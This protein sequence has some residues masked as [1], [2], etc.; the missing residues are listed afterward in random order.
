MADAIINLVDSDDDSDFEI[1]DLKSSAERVPPPAAAAAAPIIDVDKEY[2][3]AAVARNAI[4]VAAAP[5]VSLDIDDDDDGHNHDHKVGRKRKRPSFQGDE[6]LNIKP[7]A[8]P[9]NTVTINQ[10]Q[11]NSIPD[12][13]VC[14]T[15]LDEVYEVFPDVDRVYAQKLLFEQHNKANVVVAMLA[16]KTSY[17]KQKVPLAI[18]AAAA[19]PSITVKLLNNNAPKFDYFSPSS[20]E[21]SPVYCQQATQQLCF[22]FPYLNAKAV[23]GLMSKNQNHYS[24]VQRSILNALKGKEDNS[25]KPSEEEEEQHF[26]VLRN[27]LMT[28]AL[29]PKQIGRLG[30]NNIL[31]RNR[32]VKLPLITDKILKDE[33]AYAKNQLQEWMK[34]IEQRLQRVQARKV[35]QETGSAMECSCCFDQVAM[36]EMVACRDEGHLFCVDCIRSYAE[37]Q[38]FSCGNLGI[39]KNTKKPALHLLCCHSSGCQSPFQD[40]HLSKALPDK[41][42]QK[43]NELQFTAQVEQAGLGQDLCTCPKC[44]FQV[45]LPKTQMILQCPVEDCQFESCR[46]CGKESHIPYKCD[47]VVKLKQQDAGRLK[48]EEAISRAKIRT[49]PKCK[50]SF[51]KSDG[52]NKMACPCGLKLCYICRQPLPKHNPYSHFC[53]LPHCKHK[54]CGKCTLYSNNEE[55]DARAMREAGIGAAEEYRSELL[56]REEAADDVQINVDQ[57]LGGSSKT[58]P[59]VRQRQGPGRR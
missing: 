6:S 18:A 51:I 8:Q 33:I 26:R 27:V 45:D 14:K 38:I 53:Q 7:A 52:C 4:S 36:E 2:D 48:V 32:S 58:L 16:E 19:T 31:K 24:M 40:A 55:D 20:F 34:T 21:P 39:D 22:E 37:S 42:L 23:Q 46:N 49:C 54:D 44:G 13:E 35:S 15:P 3:A 29:M 5:V 10:N 17:P 1:Y 56:M 50:K 47:E 28:K 25:K 57:I 41:T 9:R 11:N 59:S 30:R 43:Y 12:I